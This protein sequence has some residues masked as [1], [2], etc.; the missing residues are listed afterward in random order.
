MWHGAAW[1]FVIWGLY[2][3][4]FILIE[5]LTGWGKNKKSKILS[6][7]QHIYAV[8]VFLISFVIFRSNSC[9]AALYYFQNMFGLIKEHTVY[10][11]LPTYLDRY[12]MVVLFFA[13]LFSFPVFK[14]ILNV[15]KASHQI[16]MN[17][18]LLVVFSLS[19]FSL[20]AN[21]FNPF[22]YFRF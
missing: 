11:K 2:N 16:I 22:I 1:T 17:L 13:F 5:L 4:F 21:T 6:A 18:F 19:V 10:L 20:T 9:E 14:N 7:I 12:H 3:G 8:F 15:Q